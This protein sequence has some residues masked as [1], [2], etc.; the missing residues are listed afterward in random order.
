MFAKAEALF[1]CPNCSV[2]GA[3]QDLVADQFKTV[4]HDEDDRLVVRSLF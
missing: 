1:N 2:V 3:V 4:F